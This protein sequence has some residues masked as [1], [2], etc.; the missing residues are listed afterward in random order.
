L[1]TG[2]VLAL[3]MIFVILSD[4]GPRQ[5]VAITPRA[6]TPH[7]PGI[8]Q[9]APDIVRPI[10]QVAPRETAAASPPPSARQPLASPPPGERTLIASD[11]AVLKFVSGVVYRL[12]VRT[13]FSTSISATQGRLALYTGDTVKAACS[14]IMHFAP[15]PGSG[16]YQEIAE[17]IRSCD[18]DAIA[19]VSSAQSITP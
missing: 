19:N 7:A 2:G 18:G 6:V 10:P 5:R 8:Q 15:L 16:P 12:K 1:A 11:G 3:Y 9:R 13:G 4:A 14:P 17:T